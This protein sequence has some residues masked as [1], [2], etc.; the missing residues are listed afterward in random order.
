MI[1][2]TCPEDHDLL[3][4]VSGEPVAADVRTHLDVCSECRS[5]LEKLGAEVASLRRNLEAGMT[6]LGSDPVSDDRADTADAD[7][8]EF[9]FTFTDAPGLPA[10]AAGSAVTIGR[11]LVVGE[12]DSGGQAIVYRVVHPTL[13]KDLV[14][15]LSK[16][17]CVR[18]RADRDRMVT[19]AKLLAELEHPNLVPIFDLDFDS[20]DRP[21]LVMEYVRGCNLAQEA[22][23]HRPAPA[24]P[25][26]GWRRWRGRW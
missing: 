15:K 17:P 13:C 12:L 9:D 23:H 18:D 10:M 3:P 20:D 7:P 21:F 19:E 11:Y 1:Q 5:R 16:Q 26:P 8:H 6:I 4:F 25:P 22:A 14:L 2:A 24:R